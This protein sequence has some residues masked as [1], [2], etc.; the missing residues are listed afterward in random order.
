MDY[1]VRVK[2]PASKATQENASGFTTNTPPIKYIRDQRDLRQASDDE[3]KQMVRDEL[4][5]DVELNPEYTLEPVE[6]IY[7]LPNP[8]VAPNKRQLQ[9][10]IYKGSL[11]IPEAARKQHRKKRNAGGSR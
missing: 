7:V 8:R 9:S 10:S 4:E 6:Y 2:K 11:E 5:D 1:V 3:I